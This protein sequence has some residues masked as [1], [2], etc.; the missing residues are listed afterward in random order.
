MFSGLFTKPEVDII[1]DEVPGRKRAKI[2]ELNGQI[3][4]LPLMYDKEDVSG[5][6]LVKIPQGKTFEHK[7]IK[8]EL[9]GVIQSIT[10]ASDSLKFI[11]LTSELESMQIL[12]KETNTYT[13][14]FASVQKQYETYRGKLRNITYL[15]RLTIDTSFRSLTYDQ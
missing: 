13:F 7:G 1:I 9:L 10:D 8:I 12:S 6:V 2:Y 11:S 3:T 5:R 15:L 4:R 14:K